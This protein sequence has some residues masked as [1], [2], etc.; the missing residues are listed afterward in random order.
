MSAKSTEIIKRRW[1]RTARY[2]DYIM[3]LMDRVGVRKGGAGSC[4]AG[5]KAVAYWRSAWARVITS[6]TIQ[7]MLK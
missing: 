3:A 1:N 5:W 6:P 4:G 7:Q 2:Y